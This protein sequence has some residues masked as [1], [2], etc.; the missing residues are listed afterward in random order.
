[1]G[2]VTSTITIVG[3]WSGRGLRQWW[4]AIC[5]GSRC[6]IIHHIGDRKEIEYERDIRWKM[7][8][9][10]WLEYDESKK[11]L[12][13]FKVLQR[14]RDPTPSDAAVSS[15]VKKW[16]LIEMSV[17]DPVSSNQTSGTEGKPTPL[18]LEA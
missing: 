18:S 10:N 16:S 5:I 7:V 14:T 4:N 3:S 15:D 11:K 2:C 6:C 12:K 1:M 9:I 8:G 17:D 13:S